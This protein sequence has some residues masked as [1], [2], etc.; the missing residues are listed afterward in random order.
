[1]I[2]FYK[3]RNNSGN[4]IESIT[5]SGE[6]I[7]SSI[8]TIFNSYDDAYEYLHNCQKTA[9]SFFYFINLSNYT[10]E[11][12]CIT[13]ESNFNLCNILIENNIRNNI[14][15]SDKILI[16]MINDAVLNG[17]KLFSEDFL[18][19]ILTTDKYK[20]IINN[21]IPP[22]ILYKLDEFIE[23]GLNQCDFNTLGMILLTATEYQI[24]LYEL[25]KIIEKRNKTSF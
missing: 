23:Y 12:L 3:I 25:Y 14:V 21:N 13:C 6:D 7:V 1:M 8:G 2:S 5:I 4:Y 24:E 10:I 22:H 18:N 15:N 11:K 19:Y 9:I 20:S 16:L 17:F